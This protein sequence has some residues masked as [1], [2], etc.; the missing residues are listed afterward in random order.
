MC[1]GTKSSPSIAW[2]EIGLVEGH[3]YTVVITL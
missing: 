1:A 3:A 2:S